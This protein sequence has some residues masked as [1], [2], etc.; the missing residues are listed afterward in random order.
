MRSSSIGTRL[1]AAFVAVAASAVAVFAVLT[2]VQTRRTVGRLAT[3]RRQ[4]TTDAIAEVLRLGRQRSGSWS[5]TDVHPA[6]MLAVQAGASLRVVD[7][8]GRSR[9]LADSMP[10]AMP[11]TLTETLTETMSAPMHSTTATPAGTGGL[12]HRSRIDMPADA[13]MVVVTFRTGELAQAEA[14]VRDALRATVAWGLLASAGVGL[15][16]AYGVGRRF[17]SPILAI[18]ERARRIGSGDSAAR[19]PSPTRQ[20]R[21][22][23]ELGELA[24]AID[25]MADR[26][27]AHETTRRNLTSDVA[28]ELRTPLTLLRG[29]CEE[30]IDGTLQPTQSVFASLATDVDRIRRLVDDLGRLTDA[31]AATT[32]DRSSHRPVRLDEVASSVLD[33]LRP[34]A[35]AKGQTIRATMEPATVQGITRHLEQIVANLLDNAIK[36]TPE[37]GRIGLAVESGP[38]D[39]ALRVTDNGP[40]IE[41][42]DRD[43]VFERFYRSGRTTAHP[44]N[45]I[46]LAVVQQLVRAHHGTITVDDHDP[47][48][49]VTVRFKGAQ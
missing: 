24:H 49:I 7:E 44:G 1:A 14:H 39:V 26:L 34:L 11:E 5:A 42:A 45:G 35:D 38:V 32:A 27:A 15:L 23:G 37:H 17:V 10:P 12:V 31:D 28:H 19:V 25:E 8:K 30:L 29:A 40:G 3:D 43:K 4:A 16:V 9:R 13:S 33:R 47:G 18:T 36:F 22:P 41:P 21:P 48:T 46:G 6:T 20:R 2:V